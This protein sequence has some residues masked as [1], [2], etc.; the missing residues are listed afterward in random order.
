VRTLLR[1]SFLI[2]VFGLSACVGPYETSDQGQT[3]P[4]AGTARSAGLEPLVLPGSTDPQRDTE[5]LFE[6]GYVLLGR[7]TSVDAAQDTA[8]AVRQAT[9][10]GAEIVVTYANHQNTGTGQAPAAKPAGAT[11]SASPPAN[12]DPGSTIYSGSSTPPASETEDV[13]PPVGKYQQGAAYFGPN[14]RKGLGVLLKALKPPAKGQAHPAAAHRGMEIT[15]VCQDSPAY[16]ADIM[17]GD[18]LV[19]V[20]GKPVYDQPTAHSAIAASA[21]RQVKIVVIRKKEKV[22]KTVAVPADT[23]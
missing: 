13:A 20:D 9:K 15:A 21:G 18:V 12:G 16:R 7:S 5:R 19:S 6:Q 11:A 14:P 4:A 2:L 22:F 23:W 1:A 10:L 17:A 8:G 3:P